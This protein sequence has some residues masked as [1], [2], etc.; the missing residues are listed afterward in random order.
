YD[1]GILAFMAATLALVF[2]PS[3]D[4]TTALVLVFAGYAV[5]FLVRPLGSVFFGI[6]G[7]RIG[8]QRVLVPV[9]M[10]RSVAPAGLGMLPPSNVIGV[11]APVL[12]VLLR[13]LQ[14]FS[15]G[16]EAAGAM[17][18]LAEHAPPHRRGLNTSLAQI[19]SFGALLTGTLV[20]FGM[21]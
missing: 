12:L 9:S 5:S 14:G 11:A 15:V 13:L 7:D 10:L 19:A 20:A 2:F 6:L 3:D 4:A 8:G 1:N 17:S 21:S 16:G 18:F